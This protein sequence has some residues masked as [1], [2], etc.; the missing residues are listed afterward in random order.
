MWVWVSPAAIRQCSQP[1]MTH[2]WLTA[3]AAG[4]Q[5]F[6]V[7]A[8]TEKGTKSVVLGERKHRV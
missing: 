7:K 2:I 3:A 1:I 4:E 6:G 8:V 5:R